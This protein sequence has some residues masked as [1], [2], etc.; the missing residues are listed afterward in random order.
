MSDGYG[1]LVALSLLVIPGAIIARCGG[2]RWT[3]AVAVGP[4]LTYGAVA[5]AIVPFGAL[6]VPWNAGT[7]LV[8][9]AVFAAL[10]AGLRVLA[11]RFLPD[12]R[13][14]PQ[15]PR[16]PRGAALVTGA[17]VVVG[18]VLI[19]LAATR[20]LANW[21][22]IPSTWDAVWH[23]NTV[24]FILDTGQASPTHMGE[25]RNVETHEALYYP[26]TFHALAA[27][28]AQVTGAAPATAYTV[29]SVAVSC[30]LFP[31]SA[32]MLT[33]QLV[34][35]WAPPWLTFGAAA[36]SAVLAASFTAV[37]Y[38]EFDT[39]S[40]ANLAAYGIA[41]AVF[42][43]VTTTPAHRDR[44]PMAVLALVGVFSVHITGGVVTVLLVAAWWSVEVLRHPVR[45]RLADL[46]TL[47][48]VAAPSAALL[49]P[50]FLGVLQ[51][52]EI[53]E[54]HSFVTHQG[55]KRALFDAV[56]QHTRHLNDFPIQWW[57]IALAAAG[58]ILLVIRRVWWPVP[59]WL[60]LVVSIVHSSAPFGG[61]V[62]AAI[63][64][65]SD[66]FYSDPRRLSAVIALLL[67]PL[68]GIA[69]T[70]GAYWVAERAPAIPARIRHTAVAAVLAV[71]AVASAVHYLPRH[72]FLF[73][74]KYDSVI[75][76]GKDLEAFAYLATL[77]GAH[78][79][80]IANANTDGTAWMY[81]IADL[82]PLW[83][84]YDYPVQQGPGY[85]R[86]IIWAYADD[87]DTDPRVAAAVEALNIRYLLVSTPVVRGFV[88]PDGLASL[89][90]SRSWEKI[91]DNGETRIYRWRGARPE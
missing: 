23:A 31:A 29:A 89:D 57:L 46:G 1:V 47:V 90:K 30:W 77:P 41:V 51:E 13:D 15:R 10:I 48:A 35:R 28:F 40:I 26:S 76:D 86:F 84:H 2:L 88:I 53:I 81:A 66:L 71:A 36:T 24:R 79:T 55:R 37:P 68:A 87:A 42:V 62:G 25:L 14:L 54:G 52:A 61:P 75:I 60:L 4:A 50:Q 7:A 56:V 83:T 19:W 33:W 91:Y 74:E 20:G 6:G 69:A 8:T 3:A 32:A 59:V 65:F 45:R 9:F 58:G 78:D 18:A 21:Q 5:M 16:P 27:V 64:Q 34:H 49:L 12:P 82:H 39:A 80:L 11:A 73:G 38:V 17:G 70:T 44:I 43:L 22:S 63:G 67:S 85:H 72:E